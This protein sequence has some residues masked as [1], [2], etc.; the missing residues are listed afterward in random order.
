[1]R[2]QARKQIEWRLVRRANG[3]SPLQASASFHRATTFEQNDLYSAACEFEEEIAS[4][5]SWLKSKGDGFRPVEQKAGFDNEH[6]AEWEEIARWW[7]KGASPSAEV[8]AFFDNYVHDSRAWFKLMPGNPDNEKD[9]H[10]LLASWVKRR[11]AA[12][13]GREIGAQMH[14]RGYS[15]YTSVDDGL[16]DDERRA[17]DEYAKTGKI[18]HV[19]TAGREPFDS[20][21]K[22]WG[23]SGK[24][25]Y[26]RYRKIYGGWDSELISSLPADQSNE[27]L[28]ASTSS[29]T[30]RG[31]A[32]G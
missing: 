1:M 8:L 30:E 22:S 11:R 20:S 4:F 26:L 21:W 7:Q 27:S 3:K 14:G 32:T 12:Q 2:E 10:E 16:S 24:A 23:L 19:T 18:P 25:G 15:S 5:N 31:G 28:L 6:L 17:A 13:L 9:M 29:D